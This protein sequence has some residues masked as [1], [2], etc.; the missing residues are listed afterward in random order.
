M[1]IST[2]LAI[3]FIT[4][5]AMV[6]AITITIFISNNSSIANIDDI[7]R[8]DVVKAA[9]K[10]I[11]DNFNDAE[12]SAVTV[13][14]VIDDEEFENAKRGISSSYEYIDQIVLTL[15]EDK[16]F[17]KYA[18]RV[19][20]IRQYMEQWEQ[21]LTNVQYTNTQID[22]IV[23]S[24][25]KVASNLS[26][27]S[28]ALYNTQMELWLEENAN[29]DL[30][31][32]DK[33]RRAERL[34]SAIGYSNVIKEML[35]ISAEMLTSYDV[36]LNDEISALSDALMAELTDFYDNSKLQVNKDAAQKMMDCIAP[37]ISLLDEFVS[38]CNTC[39]VYISQCSKL[40][41]TIDDEILNF[42]TDLDNQ[43][44]DIIT[45]TKSAA[46]ASMVISLIISALT[47][48]VSIAAAIMLIRGIVPPVNRMRDTLVHICTTGNTVISPENL[49]RSEADANGK[50]EIAHCVR[51]YLNLV[52]HLN[53][54][55]EELMKVS[56]GDL[57]IEI[58]L[59]SDEDSIGK[60]VSH[61]V[62]NLNNMFSQIN[63]ASNE[64]AAGS[65]Q[66]S[67]SATLLA[68]SAT[69][70]SATVE[71]LTQVLTAS[72]ESIAENTQNT[73]KAA[74]QSNEIRSGVE[75]SADEMNKML[76]AV[77][78]INEA[79]LSISRV[80]KVIDDIAFQT[81]ILAL[82]ASVEAAR[83]GEHGKGFAVV[84]EEVRN[85][86]SKSADAASESAQL[87]SNSI[88]KANLGNQIAEETAESLHK[89]ISEIKSNVDTVNAIAKAT[90]E[91]K[92]ALNDINVG[93]S[94]VGDVTINISS[95]AEE[96]A[97]ASEEMSALANLLKEQISTFKLK[98]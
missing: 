4:I 41:D 45:R 39:D 2:K 46:I 26:E 52:A 15:Q 58:K 22:T 6:L 38:I 90:A 49:K 62:T 44:A 34:N 92:R 94:E 31:K 91:Q 23:K 33:D 21:W 71:R 19:D 36:A 86:A 64:V 68:E 87:I 82:N 84:A 37:Y 50:D 56:E 9:A 89:I 80:M 59:L 93:M 70:Q 83:A 54:I 69:E 88:E 60:A 53:G 51:A 75:L 42:S 35:F 8:A 85:L 18:T 30:P 96:S 66:I 81:N 72:L 47:L 77:K 95:S 65:F 28:L 76:A 43:A 11:S 57:R 7:E 32:A 10:Q 20:M 3:A 40:G 5:C 73:L 78:D 13:F 17:Y 74:E 67:D 61:M 27:A 79:S 12:V 25:D 48:L 55:N 24:A 14:L 98:E 16:D 63:T 97:A 1:K 29:P